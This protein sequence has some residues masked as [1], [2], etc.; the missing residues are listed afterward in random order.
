VEAI[1]REIG[2]DKVEA[3]SLA[4][5]DQDPHTV[6]PTPSLM[7]KVRGADML[8]EIGMQ[9]ELWADQVADGSGNAR[10][11]R[12]GPGRVVLSTGIPKLEVPASI[13]R[14]QGDVHPEGNPHIWLDP[15]RAKLMAQ[16]VAKALAAADPANAGY[17]EERLERFR[18]GSTRRCSAT[19]CSTSSA[20]RSSAASPSRAS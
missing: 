5:G 7:K 9:L 10:I 15:I 14:S 3:F 19:S 17:Y 8:F 4:A 2:G 18:T 1:V 11:L 12:A 13:S 6:S 16:N 20:R